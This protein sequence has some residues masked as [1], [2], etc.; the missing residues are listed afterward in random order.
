VELPIKNHSKPFLRICTPLIKVW[1]M[2]LISIFV[3]CTS[4][5]VGIYICIFL[6]QFHFRKKEKKVKGR[7]SYIYRL[8]LVKN[9][10]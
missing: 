2:L 9:S 1:W 10:G 5:I 6:F 3:Y 8:C 4:N 7:V